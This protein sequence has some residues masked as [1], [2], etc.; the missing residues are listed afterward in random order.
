MIT[1]ETGLGFTQDRLFSRTVGILDN[2]AQYFADMIGKFKEKYPRLKI[3]Y[4]NCMSGATFNADHPKP[5][6]ILIARAMMV[7]SDKNLPDRPIIMIDAPLLFTDRAIAGW[8]L[9]VEQGNM[10]AYFEYMIDKMLRITE[11]RFIEYIVHMCLLTMDPN[12]PRYW[13]RPENLD[14]LCNEI[15]ELY[16]RFAKK[17]SNKMQDVR[18]YGKTPPPKT[19]SPSAPWRGSKK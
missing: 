16:A 18:G 7:S 6:F 1:K 8:T 9:A 17:T 5:D 14:K 12:D 13:K 15:M 11:Q 10:D 3:L 19:P 2:R 4:A